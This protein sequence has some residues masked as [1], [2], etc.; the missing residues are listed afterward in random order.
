MYV[1]VCVCEDWI[2]EAEDD[3]KGVP[4]KRDF[5]LPHQKNL[6]KKFVKFCQHGTKIF[7]KMC[8]FKVGIALLPLSK[9][10]LL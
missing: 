1:W 10:S 3:G 9:E 6:L 2:Q 4:D 5:Q 8:S 7:N